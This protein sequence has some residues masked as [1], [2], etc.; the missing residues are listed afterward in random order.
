[1]EDVRRTS[2]SRE[3]VSGLEIFW[4]SAEPSPGVPPALYVHGVPTSSDDWLPF[5][6]RTGGVAVDLPGFGRSGKPAGF[7]YS[8][9]GYGH[10]LREFVDAAGLE[11][12]SLVVHD[13]GGVGL[14]LAQAVPER[15]ERLVVFNTVVGLRDYRWHRI[16]RVWR[17]PLAGELLMGFML[18]ASL[19]LI[20]PPTDTSTTAPNE[21]SSSSTG[22]RRSRCSTGP[23]RDSPMCA[24][25]PSSCGQPRTPTS[26]QDI[27]ATWPIGSAA[28]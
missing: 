15:V 10:F 20:S 26:A 22:H 2:E 23:V 12:F 3:A 25:R 6:H 7:D 24:A 9:D 21:R 19:K 1:V 4:R 18:R 28:E 8:I 14:A 17:T 5:L 16:A 11:R 13:W 27:A